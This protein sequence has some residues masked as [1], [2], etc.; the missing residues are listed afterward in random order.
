MVFISRRTA[1][2]PLLLASVLAAAQTAPPLPP[3]TFTDYA[4]IPPDSTLNILVLD[5]LNTPPEAQTRLRT[6]LQQLARQPQTTPLALFGLT[7]HLIVLQGFTADP[8]VLKDAAEHKLIPR[9]AAPIAN[10]VVNASARP[11]ADRDIQLMQTAANLQQFE[12]GIKSVDRHL[13]DH[14]TLDA[15]NTLAH[16]LADLPGRKNILWLSTSFPLNL[17]PTSRDATPGSELIQTLALLRQAHAAID[18][19]DA[20][21]LLAAPTGGTHTALKFE[22]SA[23]TEHA[24][25]T[26]LATATG[27]TAIL[28]PTTLASALQQA[29]HAPAATPQPA[30]LPALPAATSAPTPDDAEAY[31]RA[32]MARGAPTPADILFKV[33]V[34]PASTTAD[35]TVAPGNLQDPAYI[36][37]GPWQRYA[38]D[39]VT[40]A[41]NFALPADATG[42]HHGKLE[43][44]AYVY[45]T[46]G[47][48]LNSL[49]KTVTVTLTATQY[50]QLAQNALS[51]H[52]EVS[53]PLRQESYLRLALHDFDANRI[54]VVEVPASAVSR[55]PPPQP[56]AAR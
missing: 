40:L 4:A 13:R 17:T 34:L 18:P 8:S 19:L 42:V 56:A 25:M 35:A 36:V 48:L 15:F 46:D 43:A 6:Q 28:A 31:L 9:G 41:R 47:R 49:G 14:Y 10:A 32:V 33:R 2:L 7:N 16:C 55:L 23:N 44:L 21:T 27:G 38:I 5:S 51:F 39:F 12:A 52:L 53:V 30:D 54:G 45:D 29:L 24:A 11:I 50:A 20:R 22:D 3:G 26:A 37:P 1:L